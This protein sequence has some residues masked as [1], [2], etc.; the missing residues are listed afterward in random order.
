MGLL[1]QKDRLFPVVVPQVSRSNSNSS[2]DAT[3]TDLS[4]ALFSSLKSALTPAPSIL[5]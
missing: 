1:D 3:E 2:R 4:R 5:L